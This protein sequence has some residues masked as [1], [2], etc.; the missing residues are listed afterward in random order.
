M[1]DNNRAFSKMKKEIERLAKKEE[2]KYLSLIDENHIL[3][4]SKLEQE[5]SLKAERFYHDSLDETIN[6][7][8]VNLVKFKQSKQIALIEKRNSLTDEIFDDVSNELIKFGQSKDYIDWLTNTIKEI[9]L[10][11]HKTSA[12]LYVNLET[13][14]YKDDLS[15]YFDKVEVKDMLGGFIIEYGDISTT[16]DQSFETLI[17]ENKQW[18]YNNSGLM[19]K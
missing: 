7:T 9:G 17:N 14:K 3:N 13:L 15:K 12:V 1:V 10:K 11:E 6:E 19:I 5:A 8:K 18:F 2:K 4:S 16:I